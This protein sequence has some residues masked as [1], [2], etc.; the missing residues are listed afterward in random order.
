MLDSD[1][2]LASTALFGWQNP[3]GSLF[4]AYCLRRCYME[5]VKQQH[6]H[7]VSLAILLGH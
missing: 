7:I 3:Q 6:S 4:C 1:N 5:R 2:Y